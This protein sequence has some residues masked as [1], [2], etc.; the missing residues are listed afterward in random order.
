[1]INSHNKKILENQDKKT[2]KTNQKKCNCQKSKKGLCPLNGNCVISNVIYEATVITDSTVKS[3][4]GLTGGEFKK[5]W[6]GQDTCQ[7]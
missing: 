7:I 3:Y 5:R 6:Y 2:K 1:M 4:V